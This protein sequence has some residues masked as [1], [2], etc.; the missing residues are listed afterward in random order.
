MIAVVVVF[1]VIIMSNTLFKGNEPTIK[2]GLK[3]LVENHIWIY[4]FIISILSILL[5]SQ[6]TVISLVV[7]IAISVGLPVGYVIAFASACYGYYILSTYPGDLV[8]IRIDQSGTTGVG[9]YV[10]NHSFILPFLFH[11]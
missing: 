11:A 7:P 4:P 9:K 10:F 2:D 3:F 1:G 5:G 6:A 8:A